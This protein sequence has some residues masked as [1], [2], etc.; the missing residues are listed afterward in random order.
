MR[1]IVLS[2]SG[3]E[4]Q[5]PYLITFPRPFSTTFIIYCHRFFLQEMTICPF[6]YHLFKVRFWLPHWTSFQSFALLFF[7]IFVTFI[8][9]KKLFFKFSYIVLM[10]FTILGLVFNSLYQTRSLDY[11]E[12]TRKAVI[13]EENKRFQSYG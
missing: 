8:W 9:M 3:P 11:K 2:V 7:R 4:P 1:L 6:T 12:N 5:F 10:Y 13:G